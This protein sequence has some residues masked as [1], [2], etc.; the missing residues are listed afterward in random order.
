MQPT[1]G[2]VLLKET[3]V[4]RQIVQ[5]TWLNLNRKTSTDPTVHVNK[6]ALENADIIRKTI[7]KAVDEGTYVVTGEEVR[8]NLIF[9]E[10]VFYALK[11]ICSQQLIFSSNNHLTP[12]NLHQI[13]T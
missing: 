12:A 8:I 11:F 1:D 3:R 5:P 13:G 6:K 2:A 4:R 7:Q 10:H 9:L